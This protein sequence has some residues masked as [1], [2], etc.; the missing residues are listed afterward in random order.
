M[1]SQK[2]RK[3][4]KPKL[5]SILNLPIENVLVRNW[6]FRDIGYFLDLL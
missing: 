1:I 3:E 4:L 5:N 2:F 6:L